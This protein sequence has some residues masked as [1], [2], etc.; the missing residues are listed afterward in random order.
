[1]ASGEI[2]REL[3]SDKEN[4][5]CFDCKRSGA[6]W[7]SVNNSIFLCFDCSSQHRSLGVQTSFVRSTTMDSWTPTQLSIM[8]IGGNK[9][10]REY[11][12]MYCLPND[13]NA[14]T[15]YNCKALEYYREV[16]KYESENKIFQGCPPSLSQSRVSLMP[17]PP[18]PSRPMP[19]YT[20]ISSRPYNPEPEDSSWLGSA[21]SYIGGTIGKAS[22]IVS[23]TTAGDIIDGIRNVTVNA[24]DISKEIGSNIAGKIATPETLKNIGQKSVDALA[25]VGGFAYEGAQLAINRV[26]GKDNFTS[27]S[28][29]KLYMESLRSGNYSGGSGNYQ[30]PNQGNYPSFNRS[31]TYSQASYSSDDYNSERLNA[32]GRTTGFF[33]SNRPN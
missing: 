8:S 2:F 12:E 3:Q 27:S 28:S 31:N 17:P 29:E 24:I 33:L 4:F 22:E 14:F 1:M 6:Q 20:S 18:P 21:K 23:G 32:P 10:L 11:M 5:H 30:P 13:M 15:K 26:K 19:T 25:T 9:R 7:A 16:L